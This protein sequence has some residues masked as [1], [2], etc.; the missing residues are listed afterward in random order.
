MQIAPCSAGDKKDG[1]MSRT[2]G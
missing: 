2:E 1:Q